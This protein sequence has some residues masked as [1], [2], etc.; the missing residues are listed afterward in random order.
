MAND[1]KKINELAAERDE[2]TSELEVLS[3]T[4]VF[5]RDRDDQAESDAAT[6][7][8]ETA[9]PGSATEPASVALLKSNLRQRDENIS[10]LQYDV[11]QLRA[12]W[13]GLE[14][15][16]KAREALTD[17]VT[18]ELEHSNR[19]LAQTINLLRKRETRIACLESALG[20]RSE[21]LTEAADAIEQSRKLVESLQSEVAA[22]QERE[23]AAAKQIETLHG[24]RNDEAAKRRFAEDAEQAQL[25]RFR[26][27]ENQYRESAASLASLQ[28]YIEGRKSSWRRQEAELRAGTELLEE[29]R[30]EIR[31]LSREA[32]R[33]A[34]GLRKGQ[35]ATLDL[36][37]ERDALRSTLGQVRAEVVELSTALAE[38]EG[39]QRNQQERIAALTQE[40]AEVA[41][42]LERE[43]ARRLEVEKQVDEQQRQM[44]ALNA[45]LA[46]LKRVSVE[47]EAL[48]AEQQENIQ[49]LSRQL[50]E[51]R[52]QSVTGEAARAELARQ[53]QLLEE[54]TEQLRH[55]HA[56][57]AAGVSDKEQLISEQRHDLINLDRRLE[58][59]SA[60]FATEQSAHQSLA[61]K[62]AS[63]QDEAAQLRSDLQVL[64]TAR[65]K[66]EELEKACA[67]LTGLAASN[68]DAVQEL[69][70][71]VANSDGYADVLRIKL[72]QQLAE[73]ESLATGQRQAE[74]ALAE[75]LERVTDLTARLESEQQ[76]SAKL[77][78]R[79]DAAERAFEEEVRRIRC[80]LDAAGK[81]VAES[82]TLSEQLA[83]DLLQAKGSR[84]ELER[85]LAAADETREK[86]IKDLSKQLIQ[87][88][89]QIDDYERKITTKDAAINA[90]LSELA[91]KPDT[92]DTA[93]DDVVHLLTERRPHGPEERSGPEKDRVTRLLI[94]NIDGQELRFPLFKDKLTIGRTVHNDIQLKA[95]YISRRH[96]LVITEEDFTRIVDWGSKNGIYVNGTRVSERVLK[97]GDR[98][99]VG[100]AD[101]K[102]EE[103]PKR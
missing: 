34:L 12:R 80:E 100:S 35:S 92:R 70:R 74:I 41:P 61:S 22:L 36:Q 28:Q 91:T 93:A 69:K 13:T 98:V 29:Q 2:D 16:L 5:D 52:E 95:Q 71:K 82:Q 1:T 38:K 73:C 77:R 21:R 86:E 6:H 43:K 42:G 33:S 19:K 10:N 59:M 62:H 46:E 85:Q 24:E 89:Q 23:L 97:N 7:S 72:Q 94:G 87:L 90:L 32:R 47:K 17:N 81:A 20:K 15:E 9:G 99:T 54:E 37:R 8:F 49:T 75:A 57:L 66:A 51:N 101:F 11:E 96:A 25:A 83:S 60:Q 56:E 53:L 68:T 65:T 30:K 31:R 79:Q 44:Q 78:E 4:V 84:Q 63:L 55:E 18:S 40:L 64:T 67:Q 88:E 76:Q 3:A 50:E 102:F 26:Q 39:L 27:L 58:S 14:K 45:E 103:R 48:I